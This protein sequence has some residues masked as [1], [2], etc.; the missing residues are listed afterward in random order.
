MDTSLACLAYSTVAIYNFVYV[1][2]PRMDSAQFVLSTF[3]YIYVLTCK[4]LYDNNIV[5]L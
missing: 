1:G 5:L 2:R 4:T 3:F